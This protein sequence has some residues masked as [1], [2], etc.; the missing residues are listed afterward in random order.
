MKQTEIER[1]FL[2][3]KMPEELEKYPHKRFEQGY[4]STEPVLRIRREGEE[5]VFTYKGRGLL[6]R[7]E[8]N[9]PLTQEA[10]AHLLPKAD[11]IVIKKTRYFI[12]EKEGLTIELDLFLEELASLRIAEVEFSDLKQARAYVPPAWFG[13]EITEVHTYSNS[14]MS[15]FGLPEDFDPNLD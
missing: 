2:I 11:G 5:Y 15:R 14:A 8:Y 7:E 10:Y 1:R 13:R 9:L 3:R 6:E 12:P 4:L